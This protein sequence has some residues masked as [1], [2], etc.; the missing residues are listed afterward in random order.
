MWFKRRVW[1]RA[2]VKD[3]T[4]DGSRWK[5]FFEEKSQKTGFV[6]LTD[7]GAISGEYHQFDG[8]V[9]PSRFEQVIAFA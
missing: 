7:A 3:F 4:I 6:G 9:E 2:T 8:I 1:N 5:V